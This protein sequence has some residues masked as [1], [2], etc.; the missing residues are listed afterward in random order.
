MDPMHDPDYEKT[1]PN[2]VSNS[3]EETKPVKAQPAESAAPTVPPFIPDAGVTMPVQ[4][5]SGGGGDT[6]PVAVKQQKPRHWP[7]IVGGIFLILIL[8]SIGGFLGYQAAL[9]LRGAKSAEQVTQQ[10]TEQ[11]MLALKDQSDGNL[12]MALSRIEYVI[13]LDPNFPGAKEKMSEVMLAMAATKAP[14]MAAPLPTITLTPT[15]DFRSEEEI[16]DNAKQLMAAKKWFDALDVMD[17]LRNKNLTYKAIEVDGMYYEAL[18]FRGM[19][20]INGGNLE[21]GLYDLAVAEQFAPLDYEALGVRTWARLYLTGAAFWEV[22]WDRVVEIF[23]QIYPAYPSLRDLNGMTASERFRIASIKYGDELA[24]KG[25]YCDAQQQYDN[26]QSVTSDQQ[27]G[28]HMT[29]VYLKCHPPT[30]TPTPTGSVTPTFT[31][32][33]PVAATATFTPPGPTAG[34]TNTNTPEGPTNTPVPPTN[35]PEPPTQT[36]SPTS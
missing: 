6:A 23:A 20:K 22:K 16:F 10:A 1:Q 34:A 18:R 30:H 17:T 5:K 11:F 24:A 26:A 36:S 13:K 21:G 2:K 35:T 15:P 29:E 33:L 27:A 25:Q 31:I 7:W 8:S 14:T 3:I 28:P 9:S 32:T 12:P 19:A 4:T